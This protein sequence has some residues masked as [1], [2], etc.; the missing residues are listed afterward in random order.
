MKTITFYSLAY[1]L[2]LFHGKEGEH[3]KAFLKQFQLLAKLENWDKQRAIEILLLNLK[4]KAYKFITSDP[5]TETC[6]K[7]SEYI[8]KLTEKYNIKKSFKKNEIDNINQQPGQSIQQIVDLISVKEKEYLNPTNSN[9]RQIHTLTE[10]SKMSQC[11]CDYFIPT[12]VAG[13]W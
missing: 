10:N 2:W 7:L 12:A 3:F 6:T 4:D 5:V 11:I 1:S 9:E 13:H 8:D